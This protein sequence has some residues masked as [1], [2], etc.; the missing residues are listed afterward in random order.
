MALAIIMAAYAG[1][2]VLCALGVISLSRQHFSAKA[3]P[4]FFGLL[5]VPIAC[6]YFAFTGYFHAT[7]AWRTEGMAIGLF[8]LL[9]VIGI[10]LPLV[11]VL[12]YLLHGAWDLVHEW[13]PLAGTPRASLTGIPLAYGVFC[14]GFDWFIGGYFLTR[15]SQ[16]NA[17]RTGTS[18]PTP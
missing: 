15:R 18:P 2:G 7:D 12:A 16:W 9:G 5:L 14:A 3:E 13:L 1:I 10:R 6:I 11:L 17:A 8:A 4:L